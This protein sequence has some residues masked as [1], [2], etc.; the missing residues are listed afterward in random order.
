MFIFKGY[1]EVIESC[2][3]PNCVFI[4]PASQDVVID[5]LKL[6]LAWNRIDIAKTE[7]FTDNVKF[8]VKM[9]L[10]NI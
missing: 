9:F 2:R 10:V 6:A 1:I 7:I 8:Q 3:N 5:Q 4:F